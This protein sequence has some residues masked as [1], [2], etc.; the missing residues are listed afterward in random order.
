MRALSG[1]GNN[2]LRQFSSG[3]NGANRF[4]AFKSG[5]PGLSNPGRVKKLTQFFGDEPPLV[6]IFLRKLGYEV[7]LIYFCNPT[8]KTNFVVLIKITFKSMNS[9]SKIFILYF[10]S[11]LL[12]IKLFFQKYANLFEQEKIGMLELPYLT[13]ER[14]QK[15]GIPM[16]PRLRILQESQGPIKTEGNLSVYV[17]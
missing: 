15:I 3:C 11:C 1:S 2:G 10:L 9:M 12:K 16:G 7:R 4:E 13:E 5:V 17:V 14:L 6:R 8:L